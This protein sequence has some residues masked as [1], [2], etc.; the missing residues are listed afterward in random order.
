[1][2]FLE[3]GNAGSDRSLKVKSPIQNGGRLMENTPLMEVMSFLN[4][5]KAPPKFI[6]EWDGDFKGEGRN[7]PPRLW[8]DGEPDLTKSSKGKSYDSEKKVF[9][10]RDSSNKKA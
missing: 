7:H 2:K 6:P 3:R 4:E 10:L 8:P 9:P 1:M 5:L